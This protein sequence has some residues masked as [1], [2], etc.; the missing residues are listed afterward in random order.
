MKLPEQ[1]TGITTMGL[2]GIVLFTLAAIEYIHPLWML[3]GLFFTFAGIGIESG[4]SK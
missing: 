3:G 2:F 1:R 4:K